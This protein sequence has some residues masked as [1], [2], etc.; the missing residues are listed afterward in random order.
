[1]IIVITYVYIYIYIYTYI[2][3]Y[4]HACM[5]AYIHTYIH[6]YIHAYMYMSTFNHDPS[7]SVGRVSR[8]V[9]LHACWFIH[10]YAYTAYMHIYTRGI[11]DYG[12]DHV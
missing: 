6:T 7:P 8:P 1:M 3:T 9:H 10:W 4:I 5:H 12:H 11:H 2:H